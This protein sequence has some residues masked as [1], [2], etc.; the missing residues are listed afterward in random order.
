MKSTA[1]FAFLLALSQSVRSEA[2]HMGDR[3]P[4]NM[5][6][7]GSGTVIQATNIFDAV[8]TSDGS[9][10][11]LTCYWPTVFDPISCSCVTQEVDCTVP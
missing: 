1:I 8:E 7:A 3:T 5:R 6:S 10:V 11:Q 9:C 2:Q 4:R